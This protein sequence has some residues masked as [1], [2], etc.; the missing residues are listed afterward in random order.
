MLPKIRDRVT[1]EPVKQEWL[2]TY[3]ESL[4]GYHRHPEAKF[5]DGDFMDRGPTRRRHV[6]VKSIED[7]GK[8]ADKWDNEEPL[9]ADSEFT[10]SYGVSDTDRQT[11]LAVIRSV[12]KRRLARAAKVS[13][14]S[15]PLDESAV[16]EMLAKEFRRLFD[17]ASTLAAEDRE[18]QVSDKTL[19][20]W[21]SEQVERRGPTATADLLEYDASNLSKVLAGKRTLSARNS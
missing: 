21:I 14:R 1:R 11:M 7:I 17:V 9:T 10:V 20:R 16:N 18:R 8:E 2:R 13:T 12:S 3:S 6:L 4:R 5:L 19:V 15:I